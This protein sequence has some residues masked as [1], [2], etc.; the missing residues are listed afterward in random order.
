VSDAVAGTNP[1][2]VTL[3]ASHGTLT[4]GDT[5]N[6]T[7]SGEGTDALSLTGTQSAIDA[8]LANGLIYTPTL[9]SEFVDVL[10]ITAN[11]Q[12]HN[13]T[14]VAQSTTQDVGITVTAADQIA[15][16]ATFTVSAPSADTIA[17][18]TDHGT[19]DLT[20]PATFTGEIAGIVGTGNVLDLAGFDAANHTVVASTGLNSY[21]S[22]T[23]TTSLLVTDESNSNSVT[24]KLAGDLST[25]S[26]TVTADGNGGADIVD[27]LGATSPDVGPQVMH[28][29]GPDVGPTVVNDPGPGVGPV[30][31]ND[32]GPG[33]GPGPM[34]VNDPG[35]AA[36]PPALGSM[37]NEIL[38]DRGG[39]ST[40]VFNFA[41]VGHDTLTDFHPASDVL[42]FGGALFAN[43]QAALNATQDDGHGNT[44]ITLDP[45]DTITL[46][47][48]L[49]AQLHA[50]D[51]HF[52]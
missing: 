32:P 35:P 52:V 30:V 15:D 18:A 5:A 36:S 14:G 13:A 40:F 1:I 12:G 34:V 43:A 4:L 48:I 41:N 46:S 26:W 16:G 25:S 23:N 37:P 3:D 22:T 29:P 33:P 38:S 27:P 45:N 20:Q 39:S 49:K 47:G 8:A 21:D 2:K 19:L 51:F 44:V 6:L 10:T 28:D 9:N 42:Q 11:D 50:S 31:M 17:F 7:V 24:L